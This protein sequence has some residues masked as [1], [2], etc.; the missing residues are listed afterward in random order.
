MGMLSPSQFPKVMSCHDAWQIVS[1]MVSTDDERNINESDNDDDDDRPLEL[2]KC[3]GIYLV[4]NS[5][6][7]VKLMKK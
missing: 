6:S 5:R 1:D 3:L 4:V 2:Y 7:Y